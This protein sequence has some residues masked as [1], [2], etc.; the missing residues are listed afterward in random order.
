MSFLL[1]QQLSQGWSVKEEKAVPH[2]PGPLPA[3][4]TEV[5]RLLGFQTHACLA[6]QTI[7]LWEQLMGGGA[8]VFG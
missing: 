2:P 5:N 1:K 6:L 8:F 7:F 3:T 4:E